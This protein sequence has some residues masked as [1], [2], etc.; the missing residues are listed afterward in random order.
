[1][2]KGS[3]MSGIKNK[4]KQ[5]KPENSLVTRTVNYYSYLI[6]SVK[7][8]LFSGALVGTDTF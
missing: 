4:T 6:V 8:L 2:I 7:C 3:G 1:M 5:K